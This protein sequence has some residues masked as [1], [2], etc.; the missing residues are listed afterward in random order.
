MSVMGGLTLTQEEQGRLRVLNLVL[1]GHIGVGEAV[2]VLGVSE[3]HTWRIL[4]AYRKEGAAALAHGNRGRRPANITPE[5]I[6]DQVITLASTRYAGFNHT[7][8]TELLAEREGVTL[9]R[10]TVRQILVGAGIASPR[11]RRP[12]RHRCRRER[13]SQ[14]GMLLQMDGSY[15]DW[16]EGRGPWLTLLFAID[17]ATGSVPYALFGERETSHSYFRLLEGIIQR[18]GVPLAVYTDRHAIFH[19]TDNAPKGGEG[20]VVVEQQRTQ[21]GRAL[22]ELGVSPIFARSPQAKG[23]I[24]RAAGT[25][26]DRLVSELRL[27]GAG[28]MVE[29]NRVLLEFLTRFNKRFAVPSTQAGCAYRTVDPKVDL[30]AILCFKLRRK[31]ARDNTVK[32][33]CRTLQLLPAPDRPSYAGVR[34]EVQERLDGHLVVCYQDRVIPSREAPPRPGLFRSGDQLSQYEPALIPGWIES[35]LRQN[36]VC[37]EDRC[38]KVPSHQPAPPRQ[39]TPRQQARW[40]AVQTAKRRGLSLRVTARVLGISRNTVRR[41]VAADSPPVYPERRSD[42]NGL[43]R[44][45]VLTES[46]NS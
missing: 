15:H 46:L 26:Q 43:E 27:A 35:I 44:E 40:H 21:V 9:A 11:H 3:R 19:L 18:R 10:S 28:T 12:P 13:M 4:A 30:E 39:P 34:V 37:R 7:H 17:D 29:A 1:E 41:Y 20:Q 31:V 5:E 14:E 32:Y 2:Q 16:L 33:K 22:L 6:R 42:K 23:R 45:A 36:E 24:E 25:F 8:L 38:E